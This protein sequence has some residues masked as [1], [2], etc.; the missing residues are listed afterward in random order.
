MASKRENLK[1][2]MSNTKSRIIVIATF[3]VLLL[4]IVVGFIKLFHRTTGPLGVASDVKNIS[5]GIS[6]V[7]GALNPTQEYAELQKKQN[8][9]LAAAALKTGKSAIPTIIQSHT[10]GDGVSTVGPKSGSG[11]LDFTTLQNLGQQS[12]LEKKWRD[13][14]NKAN[15]NFYK[16]NEINGSVSD[17]KFVL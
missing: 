1:E 10:F 11:S 14:L 13:E 15:S 2:L 3:L 16:L 12:G 5:G 4:I 8:E 6:S 9:E 7:P 17:V